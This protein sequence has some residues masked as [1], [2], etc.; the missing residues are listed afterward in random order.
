VRVFFSRRFC[1]RRYD[2]LRSPAS[3][4]AAAKESL[5]MGKEAVKHSAESAARATEEALERTTE[6]VKRKVSLS[7]SPSARRRDGD[8]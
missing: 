8:L 4:K 3:V 6:K 7:R 5:E 2:V 1:G